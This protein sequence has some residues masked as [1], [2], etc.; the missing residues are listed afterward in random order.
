MS[1]LFALS[2][3]LVL[4]AGCS[5]TPRKSIEVPHDGLSAKD[6]KDM[7][8]VS[9]FGIPTEADIKAAM[10]RAEAKA[11]KGKVKAP[12]AVTAPAIAAPVVKVAPIVPQKELKTESLQ[13]GQVYFNFGSAALTKTAK[14]ELAA[15]AK[16]HAAK[17]FSK[18]SV[19]GHTDSVGSMSR[20]LE[21]SEARA[22][23]VKNY[24]LSLGMT[25]EQVEVAKMA[26]Q[27]RVSKSAAQAGL[28]RRATIEVVQ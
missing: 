8:Y 13:I 18:I 11:L 28:D 9:N 2:A 16:K 24:L 10:A 4:V 22:V 26:D 25:A 6:S 14:S 7:I 17:K 15:I 19:A 3:M 20:N 21:L 1:K 27:K 5:S 12:V 23:A